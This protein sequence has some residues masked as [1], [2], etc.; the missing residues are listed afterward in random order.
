MNITQKKQLR[1]LS[2]SRAEKTIYFQLL[3]GLINHHGGTSLKLAAL[4][5]SIYSICK[6]YIYVFDVG[7]SLVTSRSELVCSSVGTSLVKSSEV[8]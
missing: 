4:K 3:R 2:R 8:I 1:Y 5:S 6:L 7:S